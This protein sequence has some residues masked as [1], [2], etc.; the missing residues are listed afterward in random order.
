MEMDALG[1]IEL[2]SVPAGIEVGDAM[3]KVAATTLVFAQAVCPGKFVVMVRGEVAAVT[4]AVTVGENIARESLIDSIVIPGLHPQVFEAIIGAGELAAHGALG[5]IE[6][7]SLAACIYASDRAVKAADV[8]LVEIRLG[9][10]LGGKSYMVVSGDVAAV[11][12]AV[13]VG[14][15]SPKCGGMIAR[16][17]VIPAP[18]ASMRDALM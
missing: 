7:F 18:H 2:N 6:T 15:K 11:S 8:R 1:L 4:S 13:E 10:G 17:M 12:E 9:R 16:K 5:A 14:I 3:L